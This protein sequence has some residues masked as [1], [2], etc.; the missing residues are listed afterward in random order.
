MPNIYF[1]GSLG[2]ICLAHGSF[3]EYNLVDFQGSIEHEGF[4][5]TFSDSGLKRTDPEGGEIAFGRFGSQWNSAFDPLVP[6][7]RGAF[8]Y[9][10][11]GSED[12]DE[13]LQGD[14]CG[15]FGFHATVSAFCGQ[16]NAINVVSTWL[17]HCQIMIEMEAA[18]CKGL[19]TADEVCLAHERKTFNDLIDE[20]DL[21]FEKVVEESGLSSRK[22]RRALDII[23]PLTIRLKR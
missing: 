3:Y 18:C 17:D 19:E 1:Q 5:Y 8:L 9:F 15:E 11:R 22:Q 23:S 21:G 20:A 7:P 13:Q 16:T 4:V 6:D 10:G 12:D 2:E 14:A